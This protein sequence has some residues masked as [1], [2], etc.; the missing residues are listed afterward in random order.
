LGRALKFAATMRVEVRR[1]TQIKNTKTN[2]V[3]GNKT[4]IKIV[5]NKVAPPFRE[6]EVDIMYGEGISY[7]GDLLELGSSD[8]YNVIEKS[9]S[10]YSYKGD[11]IGQGKENAKVFLKEN[12]H[13]AKEIDVKV[14]EI[15]AQLTGK[16]EP[17]PIVPEKASEDEEE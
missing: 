11:K 6:V 14:R 4:K 13:I 10:W 17:T 9:G 2:E 8:R 3:S 12:P 5:K 16:G 1:S 7:E 15:E